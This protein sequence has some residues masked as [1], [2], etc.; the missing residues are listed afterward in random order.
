MEGFVKI[1]YQQTRRAIFAYWNWR[2]PK[3]Q[4]KTCVSC[5]S[6]CSKKVAFNDVVAVVEEHGAALW[7]CALL[8]GWAGSV[9]LNAAC[10]AWC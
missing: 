5:R 2:V 8:A 3:K 9:H 1:K 10:G 4:L 6:V 7:G